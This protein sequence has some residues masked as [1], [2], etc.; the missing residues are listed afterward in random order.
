MEQK[1]GSVADIY[2]EANDE[3]GK[4]IMVI[5]DGNCHNELSDAVYHIYAYDLT[6]KIFEGRIGNPDDFSVVMKVLG[7]EKLYNPK[8]KPPLSRVIREG[9]TRFCDKCGSSASRSGFLGL[10]G[11]IVCHNEECSNGH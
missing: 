5:D 9:S 3:D 8:P 1:R 11:T 4:Y 6:N 7:F 10:F 2:A